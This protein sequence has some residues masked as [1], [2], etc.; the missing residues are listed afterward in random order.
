MHA[1]IQCNFL[2]F[3]V[4]LQAVFISELPMTNVTFILFIARMCNHM[5]FYLILS[6][7]VFVTYL[8]FIWLLPVSFKYTTISY[9]ALLLYSSTWGKR[10]GL[11]MNF[12]FFEGDLP[13]WMLSNRIWLSEMYVTVL[14]R[15]L[16]VT[17]MYIHMSIQMVITIKRFTTKFTSILPV[18]QWRCWLWWCSSNYLLLYFQVFI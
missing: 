6:F 2:I 3:I 4:F 5:N 1:V 8:T 12:N 7:K 10:T 18:R 11:D 14:W 16:L 17:N 13:F 9:I 15:V